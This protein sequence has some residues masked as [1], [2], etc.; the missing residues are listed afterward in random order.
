MMRQL[1]AA[2]GAAAMVMMLMPS[3]DASRDPKW[4]EWSTPVNLGA[5]INTSFS[6]AAPAIS[7]DGLTL[8][9]VS[10]RPGVAPDAFGDQDLYVA[11]RESVDLP[12]DFPL[13]LGSTVN[14]AAFEGFPAL[15]RNE[16]HLFFFRAPGDIWVS[17]RKSV[18]DDL[19]G[20]GWQLPVPLGP[21]VN[22]SDSEGG[23][24][25]F[26]NRKRG[27]PQ[28]FFN[29]LRP[30]SALTDIYVAD[31]FG[32]A[33]PVNELNS[34]GTD[35]DPSITA[36][37]L[38]IFFHSNRTGSAGS[39]IYSSVRKSV[40]DRWSVPTTLGTVVNSA[41]SDNLGAISP[42]GETLFFTSMRDGGFGSND[43]YMTTRTKH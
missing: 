41:A 35:A 13:N 27:L 19:G 6:E 21:G 10:N 42:D 34:T 38:E 31:A 14:T 2:S 8:Y 11:R 33:A 7:Q 3:T 37:G 12:W 17:Y 9:F 1:V 40:L 29:S 15:S 16:H 4:S 26:D 24:A 43:L 18:H 30:G 32:S 39:D 22:T 36:D 5:G 28:L 25:Y 23:P 20:N